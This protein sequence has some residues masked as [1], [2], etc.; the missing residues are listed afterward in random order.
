AHPAGAETERAAGDL[1]VEAD[2]EV[3]AD[4][5][6]REQARRTIGRD[7]ADMRVESRR[8]DRAP[9]D[10]HLP[11]HPAEA[12]AGA[13]DLAA[14]RPLDADQRRHEPVRHGEVEA[15]EGTLPISQP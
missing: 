4:G 12:G 10:E 6:V 14:A 7:V 8:A 11:L 13:H 15:L 3:L 2:H 5:E 9:A 1:R